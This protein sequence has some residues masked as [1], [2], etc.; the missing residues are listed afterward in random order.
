MGFLRQEGL[1]QGPTGPVLRDA[2]RAMRCMYWTQV[3]E[4]M[5]YTD[6]AYMPESG[7]PFGVWE[8]RKAFHWSRGT[9]CEA[10]PDRDDLFTEL[11]EMDWGLF[12]EFV[13]FT[14]ERLRERVG[15]GGRSAVYALIAYVDAV[16]R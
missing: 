9:S 8:L 6:G 15:R 14:A 1:E 11:L 5:L 2:P 4:P 3:L 12:Y 10:S 7:R 16:N 13:Q